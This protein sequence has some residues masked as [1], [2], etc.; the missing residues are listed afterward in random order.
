MPKGI[1]SFATLLKRQFVAWAEQQ[2]LNALDSDSPTT[3]MITLVD[4]DGNKAKVWGSIH[5]I[6]EHE[7]M[8]IWGRYFGQP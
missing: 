8:I 6:A 2:D 5:R 3:S 4:F 7:H 1:P